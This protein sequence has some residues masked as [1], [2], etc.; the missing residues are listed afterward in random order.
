MIIRKVTRNDSQEIFLWRNDSYS[1]S[2]FKNSNLIDKK[3]HNKWFESIVN[4]TDHHFYMGEINNSKVG[5][6]RFDCNFKEK[7]SFV[8]INL[9][10]RYRGKGLS[11]KLLS[12]SI[13][14]FFISHQ[15]TLC[16]IIKKNNFKSKKIFSRCGFIL[17]KTFEG[18]E[19]YL[20]DV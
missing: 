12:L 6:V 2:M 10:P 14:K 13:K 20:Y 18:Y 19:Y 15:F 9:N 5:V 11:S 3:T 4:N 17:V 16:A 7:K 8:A 1:R